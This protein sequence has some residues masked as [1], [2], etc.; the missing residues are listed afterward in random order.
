MFNLNKTKLGY[1]NTFYRNLII[2]NDKPMEGRCLNGFTKNSTFI[3]LTW[4]VLD[5]GTMVTIFLTNKASSRLLITSSCFDSESLPLW[6]VSVCQC[7]KSS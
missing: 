4:L 3:I 2:C 5:E 1:V 6:V 7:P